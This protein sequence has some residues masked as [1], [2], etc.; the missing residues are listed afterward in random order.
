M[1]VRVGVA[2]ALGRMGRIACAAVSAAPDLELVAGFA[3]QFAGEPVAS[4]VDGVS[5]SAPLFDDLESFYKA[6]PEVVVD[7]TV[8]PV[9]LDVA[10]GALDVGA[11]PV[12]GATGW[13]EEDV[14]SFTDAVDEA[15][16]GAMM[17]PNFAVGAIVMM[18]LCEIAAPFFDGVEIV[19]MHHDRKKDKPSGTAWLTAERISAAS[20]RDVPIHSVR[21]PGLVAH[22]SV[23]FGTTGQTLEIRHDSL[24][25]ESFVTGILLA[26]RRVRRQNGLTIGLDGLLFGERA[27]DHAKPGFL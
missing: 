18:R 5:G 2:G 8:Y 7:L 25:R 16:V 3:R 4:H 12:V 10:R 13:M 23:L 27:P 26:I 9:S 22:Q 6:R 11:S 17:V 24:S 19:E 1:T 20:G 15:G 14:L 21:L